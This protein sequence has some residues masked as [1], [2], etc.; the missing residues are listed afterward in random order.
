MN[1]AWTGDETPAEAAHNSATIMNKALA[2][3]K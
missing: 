2:A 1:K 3:E